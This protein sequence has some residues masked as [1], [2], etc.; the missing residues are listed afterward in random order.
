VYPEETKKGE[1]ANAVIAKIVT[2]IIFKIRTFLFINSR[3]FSLIL[4]ILTTNKAW[5]IISNMI[6]PKITNLL[7]NLYKS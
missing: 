3:I 1:D 4:N 2:R 5:A 7:K 6:K